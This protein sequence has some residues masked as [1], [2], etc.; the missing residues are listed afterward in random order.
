MTPIAGWPVVVMFAAVSAGPLPHVSA[1]DPGLVITG[2][3]LIDGTGDPPRSAITV[4][5][6]NGRIAAVALDGK[7]HIPAGARIIDGAGKYVMP[8]IVDL[9]AHSPTLLAQ[10]DHEKKPDKRY[11]L[12]PTDTAGA[13]ARALLRCVQFD[14]VGRT[15][16][17]A[18]C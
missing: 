3:T 1:Q 8:G 10:Y 15:E 11:T 18:R 12:P 16:G 2:S 13:N 9:H 4:V 5:V 14:S 6:R 7:A 17:T